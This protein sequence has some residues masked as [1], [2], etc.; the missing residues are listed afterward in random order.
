[1]LDLEI[2]TDKIAE[3]GRHLVRKAFDEVQRRGTSQFLPEHILLAFANLERPFF[4]QL[5]QSLNLDP[6]VVLQALESSL[7]NSQ[8]AGG[9][10]KM[11]KSLRILFSNALQNAHKQNRRFIESGD[12]FIAAFRDRQ[13]PCVEVF[14]QLGAMPEVVI[15]KYGEQMR[16]RRSTDPQPPN[17]QRGHQQ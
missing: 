1:M 17:Q 12:L 6:R 16:H 3:S 5:L 9:A 7:G 15:E 10:I 2:F 11:P 4:N 8:S 14:R 13:N